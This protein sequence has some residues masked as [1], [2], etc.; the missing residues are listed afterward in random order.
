M[1]TGIPFFGSPS[2]KTCKSRCARC[3]E[4]LALT[5]SCSRAYLRCVSCG[6]AF[7]LADY[8]NEMDE[9]FDEA[10]ANVPMDRL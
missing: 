2:Q 6:A 8:L 7:N 4:P 5:R 3:G 9:D 10:Y 1:M